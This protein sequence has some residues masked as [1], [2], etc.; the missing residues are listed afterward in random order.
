M[1]FAHKRAT[2]RCPPL[3]GG[4]PDRISGRSVNIK[5]AAAGGPGGGAIFYGFANAVD[6]ALPT[7]GR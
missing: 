7:Q 1:H 4:D 6:K 5:S 2:T 3:V